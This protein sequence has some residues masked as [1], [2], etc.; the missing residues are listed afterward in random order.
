MMH[1]S[2][3]VGTG[4]LFLI[5]LF[6]LFAAKPSTFNT[7]TSIEEVKEI[8]QQKEHKKMSETVTTHRMQIET[9]VVM[10]VL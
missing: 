4:V 2:I 8:N 9:G 6:F 1:K 5:G 7:A 3:M 10:L